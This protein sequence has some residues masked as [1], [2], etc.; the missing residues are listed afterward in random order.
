MAYN[1][2]AI[3]KKWQQY[4]LEHK[5]FRAL[6]PG[7]AGDMPKAFVLDMFPYPSGEGLHVGHVIQQTATDII[8]RMLRMRG[9]NVLH[10]MG[11]DAFGLP[12][13]QHAIKTNKHPAETTRKRIDRFRS[14]IQALGMSYDWDREVNTTDPQY[15][16][17]TQWIFLQLFNS[18]FDPIDNKAKPISHLLNELFN[19][20]YV[21]APNYSIQLNRTQEGLEAVAGEVRLERTWKELNE[22]EQRSVID[23]QRLAYIDEAPVNWCPGLGTVLANEEVVDGKSEVGGFPVERRPMRQWMLRITKYSERLLNDLALIQWPESLKEMQRNWIGRSVGAEIDFAIVPP[24]EN[25][26]RTERASDV[27]EDYEDELA[28][29]VFTTRPDTLFGATYMVLAPEHPLVDRIT[30]AARRESVEAYRKMVASKSERDRVADT[31]DK[32]GVFIGAYAV[33]PA[34]DARL[35]IYIA[36]Y[37]LMGYGTGAIMA[38]PGQDERDW[39]FAKKFDLPII[40][41]VQPPDGWPDDQAY[42]E[43]GPAINSG[44]LNGLNVADAKEKMI[45]HLEREGDGVRSVKYKLR[46]W[47]FSRQRYWGE[48][49]PI[50]LDEHGNPTAL[51]E[52]E[53]PLTLPELADFKPTGTP[54]PPLSKA[55]E[56]LKVQR[57]GKTYTR[58]TNVMPQWAGSCWYYLRYCDPKNPNRFVD[59]MKER[60][61]MPVDLYVGGVEHAVLHLLYARFWHK[62]L[63]DLGH[64]STP[65]PFMKLVNQGLILGETEYHV[66]EANEQL[67]V[68]AADIR[69][70]DEEASEQGVQ[71]I[72]FDKKTGAKLRGRRV[73]EH[74]VE[75]RWQRVRAEIEPRHSRRCA[76]LQDEQVARQRAEPRR[77]RAR[78]RRRR[79]PPVRDVH[80]PARSAEAMEHARHRRDEPVPEQRVAQPGWRRRGRVAA[81]D[82]RED[83]ELA[84]PRSPRPD[85]ASHDQEGG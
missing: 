42:V 45:A 83:R 78:L 14:Q 59:P 3:E 16:K 82:G 77:P 23:A 8:C 74:H 68:T 85:D 37:V 50:L 67:Q 71:L 81:R 43:D 66:F 62:V 49:F 6:D 69:D 22:A 25:V 52:D 72:A 40:R 84:D 7:D 56:W 75:K 21:V 51:R 10:P 26:A 18:Y 47:L 61:W 29:T 38:V 80:G 4:W 44:F 19:E 2:T 28:I 79:L 20:N 12:A 46:D 39:A 30:P 34:N 9:Y 73:E 63:F 41:T 17:W 1:F 65:E 55:T 53:L 11:W 32:T 5:A 60:Y 24:D 54:N 31:K 76:Q 27:D 33:N 35:P 36:D 64:V 48:P 13:E 58:E 57:D 70:V 15:Y